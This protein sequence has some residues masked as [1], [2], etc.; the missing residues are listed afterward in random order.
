[1][2]PV[3][4]QY[5]HFP[6]PR[7]EPK[8]EAKRL[9]TGSPSGRDEIN[10]FLWGGARDWSAPFRVLVA[11]GG[12]GDALIMLAQQLADL[13]C[14]AEITY[15]DLSAASRA[16]AEARAKERG[17]TSITFVT[18]SLLD[19]GSHGPFDYIDC[20]GVLHHLPEPGTGFRA[21]A[22][23][24]APGGGMGVMLY[25]ELG[26][27]GVYDT[28]D[29][30][31]ALTKEGDT[32]EARVDLAK[33]LLGALPDTNRLRRNPFVKDFQT[34]DAGIYDLLLHAQ[35]R[36]YRVPEIYDA[37]DQAGLEMVGFVAPAN[38]DPDVLISD[39]K[40]RGRLAKLS[41][42]EREAFA[43]LLTGNIKRH[44]FYCAKADDG[45]RARVAS[46]APEMTPVLHHV[47]LE[48]VL[49]LVAKPGRMSLRREG[50]KVSLPVPTYADE[51]LKL[52]D[53]ARSFNDIRE[54]L[55]KPPP[56]DVFV[57]D[58]KQLYRAFNAVNLMLL[59]APA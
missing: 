26:R 49:P 51:I 22:G 28:Q 42:A 45:G 24:L 54:G 35:D 8:D 27:T 41:Q 5:E 15:I 19:A 17:L 43:E 4:D 39:A 3:Q 58:M 56:P 31:R 18:G 12:T 44:M 6:Y 2:D 9:I 25:G 32:G 29:M 40:L 10:H 21:L 59:R 50:L 57:Q 46:F 13:G 20:C 30:L 38:Y 53:G 37:L 14:P 47:A 7:R 16:I 34:G 11:G 33:H 48:Q 55:S 1:M 52:C 23:A 36:A